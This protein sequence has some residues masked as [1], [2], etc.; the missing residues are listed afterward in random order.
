M[1]KQSR[2]PCSF[3]P[4][5]GRRKYKV[6]VVSDGHPFRI[7]E[8]T[9]PAIADA[10]VSDPDLA[11]NHLLEVEL[12]IARLDPSVGSEIEVNTD[13]PDQATLKLKVI[14]LPNSSRDTP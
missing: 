10:K 1:F 4:S 6:I 5:A 3:P 14:F 7:L 13:H 11:V 12:D 9:G 8:V 2:R